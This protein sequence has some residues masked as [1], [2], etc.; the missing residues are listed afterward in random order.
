MTSPS[1]FQKLILENGFD[2]DVLNYGI[3]GL[4]IENQFNILKTVT[5]L[6]PGDIVVFYDGVNDLIRVFEEGLNR[7]KNQA[8][9][10]QLNDFSFA[11]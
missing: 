9:W 5:D 2:F 3:P 10:R 1:Q 4:R 8:P 7:R 11:V 6:G